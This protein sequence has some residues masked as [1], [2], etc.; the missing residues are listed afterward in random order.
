MMVALEDPMTYKEAM[1]G[2]EKK[3]LNLTLRKELDSIERDNTWTDA[4]LQPGKDDIP[5][6]VVLN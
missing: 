3:N 2:S 6:K 1:G 5:C 4:V